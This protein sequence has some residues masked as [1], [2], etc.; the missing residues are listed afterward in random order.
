MAMT[1]RLTEDDASRLRRAAAAQGVSMQ[2]AA[3]ASVR[4]WLDAQDR[5]AAVQAALADTLRRYPD[6]LRRLGE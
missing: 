1:L 3:L 5:D 6:A 4:S 2:Q